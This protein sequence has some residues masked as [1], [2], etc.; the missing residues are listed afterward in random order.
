MNKSK[1][2]KTAISALFTAIIVATAWISVPT[3]F[4]VNLTLQMF[5]VCFAGFCLGVKWGCAATAAYITIG[6]VGLPVF[7]SFMGGIGIIFGASGGFLWGFLPTVILCG[8]A[9]ITNKRVLKY[10]LM[11]LAVL[12][13]HTV[14]VIQFCAVSG[15]NVWAGIVT[16]SLPFL[17]KDFI[18]VFLAEFISKKFKRIKII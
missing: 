16:A 12:L 13:C 9:G 17:A 2:K 7:S 14:G 18:L 4:G 5:G 10:L 8:M 15:V 11:M 1:I 6:A 3:P